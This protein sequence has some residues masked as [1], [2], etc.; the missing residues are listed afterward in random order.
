MS[1]D[2]KHVRDQFPILNQQV[3][4]KDLAYLDN[5]ATT[6]KPAT[7]IDA[8]RHYYERDN[9]NV[10]RGVHALSERATAAYEAA[11]EKLRALLN[12]G[13]TRELVFVRGAT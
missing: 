11:R 3:Y 8:V 10:H 7:V 1:F 5:A 13:S 9:A 2:L 6:Q 4:G 12:I